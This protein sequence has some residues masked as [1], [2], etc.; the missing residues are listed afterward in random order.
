MTTV[1]SRRQDV[2][3]R[4]AAVQR[5]SETVVDVILSNGV[6]LRFSVGTA[7]KCLNVALVSS[8]GSW[9]VED[10]GFVPKEKQL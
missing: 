3:R 10:I 6:S 2:H 4:V 9:L 1:F 8:L 7:S 5:V